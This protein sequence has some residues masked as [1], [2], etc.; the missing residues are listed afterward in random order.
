MTQN[1]YKR[2]WM[3]K[4]LKSNGASLDD[5]VDVYVKQTRSILEFGAPVWN[6]N[7]TQNDV[8]SIERVSFTKA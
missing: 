2:L 6:P 4:R 8:A 1:A 3:V 5:L 7:L